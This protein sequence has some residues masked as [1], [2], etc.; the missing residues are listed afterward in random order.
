MCE[1]LRVVHHTICLSLPSNTT[2]A[3]ADTASDAAGQAA[4]A[5]QAAPL[6]PAAG[7]AAVTAAEGRWTSNGAVRVA[8]AAAD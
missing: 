3:T 4:T 8:A 6:Q 2:R 1:K 5:A 7:A